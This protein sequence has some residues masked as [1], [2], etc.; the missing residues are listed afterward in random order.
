MT[1][2][3]D[4]VNIHTDGKYR[5]EGRSQVE[6]KR[7]TGLYGA[8]LGQGSRTKSSKGEG[9]RQGQNWESKSLGQ[10]KEP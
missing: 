1:K 7:G 2:T 4:Q 6:E 9:H 3:G 5:A 8:I 10:E